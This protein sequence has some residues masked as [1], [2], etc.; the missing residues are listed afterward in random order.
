MPTRR[1]CEK[2]DEI[3]QQKS[4]KE[5]LSNDNNGYQ[6]AESVSKEVLL[7]QRGCR[8]HHRKSMAP[9]Q[10]GMKDKLKVDS[11]AVRFIIEK[12]EDIAKGGKNVM[13]KGRKNMTERGGRDGV[14]NR[15]LRTE[16]KDVPSNTDEYQLIAN[17]DTIVNRIKV[18]MKKTYISNIHQQLQSKKLAQ[19]IATNFAELPHVRSMHSERILRTDA[20]LHLTSR[21]SQ[22]DSTRQKFS[23]NSKRSLSNNLDDDSAVRNSVRS[24][25]PSYR[26]ARPVRSSTP[27]Y[28]SVRP[29]SVGQ[30]ISPTAISYKQWCHNMSVDGETLRR[31]GK[32]QSPFGHRISFLVPNVK[33]TD[34]LE[35]MWEERGLLSESKN[36]ERLFVKQAMLNR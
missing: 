19:E 12:G 5:M 15:R 23:Q 3:G 25:T 6:D 16:K 13:E 27:P 29:A 17:D 18:P 35:I 31:R 7:K 28:R 1:F 14:L 20:D 30:A 36:V 22:S 33:D 4:D 21:L 32:T 8:L 2:K 9:L 11:K 24:S 34:L 10:Q 26:S